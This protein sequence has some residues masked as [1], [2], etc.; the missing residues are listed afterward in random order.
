MYIIYIHTIIMSKNL[1]QFQ[2]VPAELAKTKLTV[3]EII[4]LRKLQMT[5]LSYTARLIDYH[6][7][8][9]TM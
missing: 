1:V 4:R 6:T 3:E 2:P 8:K 7:E 9:Y 5:A